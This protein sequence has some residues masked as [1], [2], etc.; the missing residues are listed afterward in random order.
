M[1]WGRQSSF[2][3]ALLWLQ[4]LLAGLGIASTASAAST[5]NEHESILHSEVGRQNNQSL[6]W[7]PYRPNLYFGVRPRIPKSLM[8]GLMWGKI[9]TY[10]DFQNSWFPSAATGIAAT[11]CR[12]HVLTST[13]L[14]I[15][16]TLASKTR[17]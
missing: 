6:L 9:E 7:G 16:A 3:L 10:N 15:Y 5:P 13:A 8:T 17:A 2:V 12:R 14:Q 4:A 11:R 1:A